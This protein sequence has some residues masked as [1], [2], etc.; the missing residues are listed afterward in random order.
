MALVWALAVASCV[1][2]PRLA[3]AR[4][5]AWPQMRL[6]ALPAPL[7]QAG[8]ADPAEAEQRATRALAATD[9]PSAQGLAYLARGLA[10]YRMGRYRS[11]AAD[12]ARS[13]ERPTHNTD[14]A[15]FFE[16]ESHFH[17]GDYARAERL[18]RRFDRSFRDSWWRHRARMRLADTLLGQGKTAEGVRALTRRLDT[19]PE[20]PH[21]ASAWSALAEA[22][23]GR[24]RLDRAAGWL[25]RILRTYPGDPLSLTARRDL[26]ALEAQ[27]AEAPTPAAQALY[28]A[29]ADLRQRKFFHPALA[30]LQALLTDPRV[31]RTLRRRVRYQIGRTLFQMERFGEAVDTFDGLA[32][33]VGQ[34][35]W[36]RQMLRWKSKA[37][38]GLGRYD[39]AAEALIDGS[40]VNTENP[41][42]EVL[43]RVGWLYFNGARYEDAARVFG[44]LYRRG[45]A[46]RGKTRFMRVWLAYRLHDYE[47]AAEGFK[48]LQAASS[49]RPARYGYW[50]ARTLVHQGE[51]E[52]AVDTYR[53]IITSAPLSYYA[54]QA[55]ARLEELGRPAEPEPAPEID[56]D[57]VE[58]LQTPP[59]IGEGCEDD[60]LA[61]LTAHGGDRPG[62]APGVGAEAEAEVMTAVAPQSNRTPDTEAPPAGRPARRVP[63]APQSALPPAHVLL[64]P[65]VE[66]GGRAM[67]GLPEA[68]ELA[69]I[70]EHRFARQHLRAF[71]DRLSAV[72][73]GRPVK[74]RPYVDYRK[75]VDRAEW[76]R[77]NDDKAMELDRRT[78][79][80]LRRETRT[81]AFYVAMRDAFAALDDQHY[82][83]R[84]ARREDR[85]TGLPQGADNV[86]WQRRYPRAFEQTVRDRAAHYGLDPYFIWAL[87]TVESSYN[88]KAISRVGAR[89][90]MQVMP[91]TGG[92]VAD[93]MTW[94]N[95]GPALLFEP[96]VA[97]EMAA[98]YF[99]QLLE[100]FRGQLPLAIAS[101]NAGPHRVASWLTS[102]GHLPL[103]EFV[104]EIPYTEAREYTKKVL[105]YLALYR[106]IYESAAPLR[107]GQII[108]PRFRDNINF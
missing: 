27:G 83:R 100:K 63:L 53:G 97:I 94:R 103:D 8:L 44:E 6:P 35:R 42:P 71:A 90:L 93:R 46:W 3:E 40:T 36:R 41:P 9:D 60:D 73:R 21:H 25:R 45:G 15:R 17:A 29:G 61:C 26:G 13:A 55:R 20:F 66:A 87:M 37:L 76:D 31:D 28:E 59:E 19:Y 5:P 68:W 81:T 57:M 64:A 84:Y 108:D 34:G 72:R 98:W 95:W 105:R 65:L 75:D 43:E 14:L 80:Y 96:E 23:R 58:A 82:A 50:L 107:V 79:R 7:R 12:L 54:Y 92:L 101:Y 24:G 2:A 51:I 38:E 48:R 39:Q 89:G 102:K 106:R 18:L 11:A 69:A 1:F 49:W 88:P 16:A 86:A 62:D 70:G 78:R 77:E 32:A 56:P 10:R 52:A 22:E 47:V 99:H 104:E 4:P 74:H 85:P 67:P 33:E 30:I 91:H